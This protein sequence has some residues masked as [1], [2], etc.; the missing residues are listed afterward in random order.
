M[1]M[2]DNGRLQLHYKHTACNQ[3]NDNAGQW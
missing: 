1:T 3:M 2:L